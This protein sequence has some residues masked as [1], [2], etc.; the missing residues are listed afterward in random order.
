MISQTKKTART[1][2]E[3]PYGRA[4]F[5]NPYNL[6]LLVG[7]VVG[8][9]VSGH[10]WLVVITCAAEALW[11]IFAPDSRFLRHV[12]F[13]RAL[14][15]GIAAEKQAVREEKFAKLAGNDR[16]R[17]L[18]LCEQKEVIERLAKD[19]PSLAVD[20][21]GD[22]LGKLDGLVEEFADLGLVASR[23]EAHASTF[24]FGAMRRSWE[25]HERQ[26]K[27]YRPG[28]PRRDIA[29][30][31]LEVL[32][33]RRKRWDDLTRTIQV[34]RGQMELI[35]QTFRLLADEI[36][37]MASPNELGGRIEELRVAVEA[38]RE[39]A[40]ETGALGASASEEEESW[41]HEEGHR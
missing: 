20:L 13:D 8:G 6:S 14:A 38:V 2:D 29:T 27:A 33:Q 26:A 39:T 35:E 41:G 11:M 1:R 5:L 36:M 25:M 30:K 4:A 9:L 16:A 10:T 12:W 3:P 18:H 7:G 37:S 34:T 22:E 32:G 21:L 31:N 24:D 19:N 28:D 23:A 17:V 40:E 15:A